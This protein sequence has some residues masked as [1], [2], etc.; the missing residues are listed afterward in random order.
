M[1]VKLSFLP[2]GD[3][4]PPVNRNAPNIAANIEAMAAKN[5]LHGF[6]DLLLWRGVGSLAAS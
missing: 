6:D 3:L 4:F 1:E 2:L 5:A